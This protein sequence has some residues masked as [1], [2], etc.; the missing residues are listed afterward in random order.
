MTRSASRN[1]QRLAVRG[2]RI[3]AVAARPRNCASLPVVLV[4]GFGVSSAY[5]VP[6]LERLGEHFEVYAPDL[7][8]HGR[9]E[10]PPEAYGIDAFGAFVLEWMDA[11]GIERA[12]LVANSMG[13]PIA[14]SAAVRAPQRIASLVLIGS[15]L[16]P[17]ARHVG[18]LLLRFVRS[19]PHER[20]S[21]APILIRDYLRM[22]GRALREFRHMLADRIETRLPRITQPTLLVR[23]AYD[24]IAPLPWLEQMAA[25]IPGPVRI[26]EVPGV[27]HAVNYSAA[28]P[29]AAL[30]AP[31]L[32]QA[33][34][35]PARSA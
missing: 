13:C 20:L 31:F 10:T 6:T 14:V 34:P 19:A 15:T 1:A 28:D 22:G 33:E 12:A 9:S 8:G 21:L 23:G 27:G 24:F 18:R 16:D 35:A 2:L 17:A 30:I 32:R 4:H 5:F 26:A 29:L 11:M 3:H 25:L 7:P